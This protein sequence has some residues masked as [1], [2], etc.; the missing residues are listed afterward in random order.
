MKFQQKTAAAM[1][2]L[3]T[4]A[5]VGGTYAYWNQ[6]ST[7]DNPFDT[8]KYGSTVVED[9]KP[10]DGEKWQPGSEVNKDV[11]AVNTGDT[12]LIVRARLDETWT[13]KDDPG[14][15]AN[16]AVIYKD[17]TGA[18]TGTSAYDVY[19]SN[20]VNAADG[21]TAADGSVVTK[22]FSTSANWIAG[23]DGWYY[24]KVNLPGG[25]TSDK[26]LDSVELLN[27]ADMGKMLTTYYVTADETITTSTQWFPYIGTMPAYILA[28]GTPCLKDETGALVVRH[29]KTETTY[30]SAN[31]L[32]YSQSDYDLKVTV[33]TV[34]PTQEA[35]DAV[36][37][38]GSSFAAPTGTN[39]T[40][41]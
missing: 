21:L 28:D 27:D 30:N 33:Q 9:F 29:N 26:W 6:T 14:T 18:S 17:S 34:Q 32:G 3:L 22:T 20:Q 36:F 4:A 40:L 23:T 11:A 12:D 5:I 37:G 35:I 39:W 13:R 2:G 38:S 1:I 25:A 15:A 24:Y 19:S 41:K 16:E 10:E 7:I 8:S 31:E